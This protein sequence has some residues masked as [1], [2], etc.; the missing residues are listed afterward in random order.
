MIRFN[1]RGTNTEQ[2]K[3]NIGRGTNHKQTLVKGNES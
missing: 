1:A 3:K 2:T